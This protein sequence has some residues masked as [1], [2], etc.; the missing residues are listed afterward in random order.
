MT[1]FI[2]VLAITLVAAFHSVS[3]QTAHAG[4]EPPGGGTLYAFQRGDTLDMIAARFGVTRQ[5]ILKANGLGHSSRV[6]PGTVLTI[7]TTPGAISPWLLRRID[8]QPHHGKVI[9]VSL[10]QQRLWAYDGAQLVF[11]FLVSTG[12]PTPEFPNRA[13]KPGVFRIKTKMP[14]AYAS[15]WDLRMP[16]WMGIYD[17]GS[18]ENG[19]H[20]MPLLRNGQRVSWRVGRPASFG[21]IVLN[22]ADAQAL[23]TWAPLGTLVVIRP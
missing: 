10:S 20:A 14:E 17:A 15:T 3:G 4:A 8:P 13:T 19:F 6:I 2:C 21:C 12:L 18:L 9:Y 7:P 22:H 23:Y 11:Q 1:R 5:A 16:F